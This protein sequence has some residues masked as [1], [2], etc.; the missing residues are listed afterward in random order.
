MATK[1]AK[2][3]AKKATGAEEIAIKVVGTEES[4]RYY[5]NRIGMSVTVLDF[6][7]SFQELMGRSADEDN[8]LIYKE[9]AKVYLSPF[10]I[11][12]LRE[13]LDRQIE[14]FEAGAGVKLPDLEPLT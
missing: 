3:A 9:L 14:S 8:T 12:A 2:K 1:A 4:P 5:S 6:A 7:L 11:K 13:L 10:Q